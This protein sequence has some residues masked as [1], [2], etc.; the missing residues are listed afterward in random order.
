GGASPRVRSGLGSGAL[1]GLAILVGRDAYARL[2]AACGLLE[3]DL[4]VVAQVGPAVDRL[5]AAARLVED[6]AEN[7]AE[8]VGEVREAR[9]A[10]GHARAR[11]DAGV[12]VAIVRSPLVR[13]G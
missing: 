3:R 9:S 7:V 11:V 12:A 6:V 13:I 1:A 8:G 10:A 4:E 5:A 2:R